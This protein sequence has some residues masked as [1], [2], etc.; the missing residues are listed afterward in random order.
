[1]VFSSVDST[2]YESKLFRKRNI[3]IFS[4]CGGISF[5]VVLF[6]TTKYDI[7]F[8]KF[9]LHCY[10]VEAALNEQDQDE[11]T[12]YTSGLCIPGFQYPGSLGATPVDLLRDTSA[13]EMKT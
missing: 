2:N 9:A 5:L 3:F 12:R 6:Q 4:A 10:Q 8:D 7:S 11:G 13:F 1:M